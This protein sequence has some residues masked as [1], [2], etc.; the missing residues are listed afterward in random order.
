MRSVTQLAATFSLQ[1]FFDSALLQK[2]ILGQDVGNP[3]V[4]S[5][6]QYA[7]TP[8]FGVALHPASQA[9]VAIGFKGGA[10]DSAIVTLTPG[11]TIM[12]GSFSQFEWGLPFGWLGGGDVILY[13]LHN[14]KAMAPFPQSNTP[15]IFHRTRLAITANPGGAYVANWPGAFPWPNAL[16]GAGSLPQQASATFNVMPDIAMFRLRTDLSAAAPPVP[17]TLTLVF[18]G[19]DAF[20][21]NS[22]TPPV[23]NTTDLTGFDLTFTPTADTAGGEF[24]L[25]WLPTEIARLV[26]DACSVSV[27]DRSAGSLY[28]A[29]FLDVVRY[30]RLM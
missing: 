24:S 9:P 21:M 20:D 23:T 6:R 30:G 5:T 2:A 29:S 1:S 22:A 16:S 7:Q 27:V 10:A 26:G 15:I 11:Q 12:T 14:E 28:I 3:I 25:A 19:I 18:R 13:V 17:A 4:A 8:G